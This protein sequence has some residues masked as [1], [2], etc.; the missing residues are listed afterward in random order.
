M[1]VDRTTL[2]QFRL[3]VAIARADGRLDP[4]EEQ[5][6][7]AML[8]A[9]ASSLAQLLEEEI[10]VD[11]ELALL[12]DEERRRLYQSGFALAKADG[13]EAMGEVSLLQ[14]IL[15]DEGEHT[16]LGQVLGESL[17]TLVP[18]HIQ[19][20]AD[21]VQREQE[22]FQDVLKYSC[23]A[24]V[25][26]A[27]PLPGVGI[28][29]DVGVVALQAKMV[30]DV[31]Q[32]WGHTVDVKGVSAFMAGAAG[33]AGLRIAVNNLARFVPG[34]GSAFGAATSF[35]STWALGWVANKWFESGMR[36]SHVELKDLFAQARTQARS[37]YESKQTQV[38]AAVNQH[39]RTL[40]ALA[41]RFQRGELTRSEYET[42]V[43]AL[44]V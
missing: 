29:A 39:Q 23:I 10:D 12:S 26:G 15:P 31:G 6:L 37:T 16:L 1:D 33:S 34:W 36:L 14:Q 17:D 41:D 30:H 18:G 25:A 8:G 5:A 13:H 42:A 2:A 43:A 27:T 32:Y 19:A 35:V 38:E 24:A 7:R 21:P 40:E 22:L 20:V 28:I 9:R 44:H 4:A 3:L 11:T